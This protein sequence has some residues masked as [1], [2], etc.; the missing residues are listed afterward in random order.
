MLYRH[1]ITDDDDDDGDVMVNSRRGGRTRVCG[2]FVI[3]LLSGFDVVFVSAV[4]KDSARS[5]RL[6]EYLP[7]PCLYS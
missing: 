4:D 1:Q 3:S 6:I 5:R 2:Q 7:P